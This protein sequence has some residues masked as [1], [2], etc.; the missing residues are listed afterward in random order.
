VRSRSGVTTVELLVGLVIVGMV[1]IIVTSYLHRLGRSLGRGEPEL[2]GGREIHYLFKWM[3]LRLGSINPAL[4]LDRKGDLWRLDEDRGMRP[5]TRVFVLDGPDQGTG[6]GEI[7]EYLSTVIDPEPRSVTTRIVRKG[8]SVL[9]TWEGGER[10]IARNVSSL[11]FHTVPHDPGVV[12]VEATISPRAD[13][14]KAS[15]RTLR[16]ALRPE[17]SR[18]V[19]LRRGGDF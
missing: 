6:G 15:S 7:L 5:I 10:T 11:K 16:T 8:N 12:I 2:V 1:A 14:R 19:F 3:A 17:A 4:S 9:E 18:V 13:A